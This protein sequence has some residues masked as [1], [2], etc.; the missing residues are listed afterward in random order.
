MD[1]EFNKREDQNK[2]KLGA[3]NSVLSEI[4]KGGGEQRLQKQ[5]DEGKLTARERIDYILML[6]KLVLL[7]GMKCM[8]NTA[9]AQVQES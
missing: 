5:R 9:V 2:L 3:I 6:L 8:K 4:K 1:L 7:R